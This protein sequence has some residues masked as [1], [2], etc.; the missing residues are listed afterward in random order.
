MKKEYEEFRRKRSQQIN[1]VNNDQEKKSNSKNNS[2]SIFTFAKDAQQ[3]NIFH[4]H[5]T[6]AVKTLKVEEPQIV[7]K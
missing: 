5:N 7:K 4:E 6:V 3:G 2:E 1:T